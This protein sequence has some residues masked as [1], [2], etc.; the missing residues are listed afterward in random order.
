M[1]PE[2]AGL[3][4]PQ[5]QGYFNRACLICAN[6]AANPMNTDGI[7]ATMLYLLTA[8]V[9]WLNCPRDASGNPAATGAP[10]SPL[11]GRV[12]SASEGSVSVQTEWNSGDASSL[13]AYLT[14]T[15]YGAEYW[16]ASAP[17]RTARYIARPTRVPLSFAGPG[18]RW[19]P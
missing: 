9:A 7:L 2:F 18:R 12:S 14:Q 15:K 4:D 6:S 11:V 5:G 13:E 1:F 10:G 3:S 16:A 19:W 8:H 17:Y